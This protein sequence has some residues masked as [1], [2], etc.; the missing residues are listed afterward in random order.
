MSS[1]EPPNLPKALIEQLADA[2]IF[3][4]RT[5]AIQLWNA[6]AEAVFGYSEAEVLG[7]RLDMIIPE[8][9]RPGHWAGF[10]AAIETGTMKHGRE[11][12]TT[13]SMRKD[14]SDLYL[15]LSFALVKDDT[16]H[17]LGAVA[18]ARDITS[19]FQAERASRRRLAELEEQ[20]K[21]RR[22]PNG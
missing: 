2:V 18:V 21:A 1:T 17:V 11:A 5:G 7:Q 3:A 15:D 14:G 9:L 6:G 4:D 13:R 19:R 16:G 12:M 22:Q 20:I 8:R 10:N